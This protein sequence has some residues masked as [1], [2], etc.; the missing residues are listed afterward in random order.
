M[1]GAADRRRG[2]ADRGQRLRQD[3]A[4]PG[5]KGGLPAGDGVRQH[6]KHINDYIGR[7]K[8]ERRQ[9]HRSNHNTRL[10]NL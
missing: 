2:G 4:L 9:R 6:N 10:T 5:P 1:Q 7:S 3:D 8:G